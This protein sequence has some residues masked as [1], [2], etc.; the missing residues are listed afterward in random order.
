MACVIEL[1]GEQAFDDMDV[2]NGVLFAGFR[3]VTSAAF[4]QGG[5]QP[6]DL[7]AGQE[8]AATFGF[9]N[10]LGDTLEQ[11]MALSR[12]GAYL[13]LRSIHIAEVLEPGERLM[14]TEG[15][16]FWALVQFEYGVE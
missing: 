2:N 10:P 14:N 7:A 12:S 6:A 8:E 3:A 9:L 4:V 13:V 11:C 15:H 16:S 5:A 1:P